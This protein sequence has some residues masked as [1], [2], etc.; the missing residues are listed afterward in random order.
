[1]K[2]ENKITKTTLFH[3]FIVHDKTASLIQKKK[4]KI[5]FV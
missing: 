1:M 5:P 2:I 4:K 3:I